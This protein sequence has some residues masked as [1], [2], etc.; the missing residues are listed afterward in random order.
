MRVR[1]GSECGLGL[2]PLYCLIVAAI[3]ENGILKCFP[4]IMGLFF[5]KVL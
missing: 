2:P 4:I 1:C 5:P 3:V